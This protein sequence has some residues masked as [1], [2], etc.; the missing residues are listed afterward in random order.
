MGEET[1]GDAVVSSSS[2]A[3]EPAATLELPRLRAEGH[4]GEPR[5]P[6]YLGFSTACDEDDRRSIQ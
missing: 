1:G 2:A 3:G 5:F 6:H 4:G